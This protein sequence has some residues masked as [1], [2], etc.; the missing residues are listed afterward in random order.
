MNS[1]RRR[2]L[3]RTALGTA[4]AGLAAPAV[5]RAA[6]KK[7]FRWRMATSYPAGL[8]IYQAGPGGA[9]DLAARIKRMSDG[10]LD[11]TVYSAG[12]IMPAFEVF[13]NTSAGNIHMHYSNSYYWSGKT[14]AAQYFTTVP[15]GMSYQGHTAWLTQGDGLALWNEV[16]EPFN[17]VVFPTGSTGAQMGGWFKE[18]FSSVEDLKGINFRIPGLAGKIYSQL[19]VNVRLLPGG[20]I[21]PALE[22][23]VIDAAEW[24]GPY[25]DRR[26]GLHDAA[27]HYYMVDWHEPAT[28]T[29]CAIN[30]SAWNEL[31]DDLK[32]IVEHACLTNHL[33]AHVESEAKN[34]DAL[35]DLVEN[36]GVV[37]ERVPEAVVKALYEATRDVL[38][39]EADKDPLVKKVNNSY[40]RF[41]KDHD[42]WQDASETAFQTGARDIASEDELIV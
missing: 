32:A 4:T 1:N 35:R 33:I 41:K 12:E 25:Q 9:E 39:E 5:L 26:L 7:A 10:R 2:F 22:R 20:E 29:E 31:P 17:L 38:R 8:P 28:T 11:I 14:F 36:E 24:V 30:K 27:K 13:D 18:P 19:G 23:G 21:F 40:W 34:A 16:Y 6:E 37:L 42:R 15:F 3:S